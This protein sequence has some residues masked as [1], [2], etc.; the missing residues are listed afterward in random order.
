MKLSVLLVG[1][2]IW[3]PYLLKAQL[4]NGSLGDP[5]VNVTFGADQYSIPNGVTTFE[6][7]GDCPG[8]GQYTITNFIFGCGNHSWVALT[9]DHTGDHDGNYM[10]VNAES[11]PGIV[12]LDTANNLCGN[13]T[14]V[15]AA[16]ISAVMQKISCGGNPILPNII[17][18]VKTLSGVLVA[19]YST[20][21][22]PL[23]DTKSW[24]QYGLSFK[25]PANVNALVLT[26]RIDSKFGC[27][28]AFVIDDITLNECGPSVTATIDGSPGPADVCADYTNPF[29]LNG[30]YTAGFDDPAD[31]WQS[32]LD[33]GRTWQDI[34][35]ETTTTY[36]VPRRL[37]G[38]IEYRMAVAERATINSLNCR[39]LS[40]PVYTEIHPL[41]AHKP[42]QSFVGCIGKD[43]ILPETDPKALQVLWTGP[44]GYDSELP[45]SIIPN[46]QYADTGL[47]KL[48]ETFYF[49]CV[50]LDTFYLKVFPGTT[51]STLPTHPICEGMSENLS[52]TSSDG[53]SFKWTPPSGLSDD[54]IPN[55][56]ASPRDS[57]TYKV[58]VTNSY[59]CKDSAYLN[60]NVYRNVAADAGPDKTIVSGDSVILNGSVKGTAVNFNWSP[61]VFMND[62]HSV[63]PKVY[64][65][66]DIVY[67]LH[68]ASTVGCGVATDDVKVKVYN[69]IVV[70]NAFTPNGD[71]LN[72]K[73]QLIPFDNYKVVKLI[74]YDRWGNLIFNTTDAYKGWDGTYN[75]LLEPVGAYVYYLELQSI[76]GKKVV[77]KGTIMLLR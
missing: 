23:T 77:K 57:T 27:G 31:Q 59:G 19:T 6:Y 17:F 8:K 12:H 13:T 22:L 4:C 69:T 56:V 73:F 45:A 43:L 58:V 3:Y 14:Y 28:S 52:A 37:S 33:T 50:S 55:P 42:P 36:T 2:I 39:I 60:V 74:I 40:N 35:G 26:I 21:D 9:G 63:N 67:T 41:A 18:D 29:I 30:S 54:A 24:K 71:G 62:S 47:Y 53:G 70:P 11:T 20:G 61:S 44:N 32:S 49:G 76:S 51:I 25:T 34:P 68:A 5:I 7:T 72:D 46:I 64:P 65:A 10:L 15:Y 16:W 48:K 75:G 38:V 1:L 66:E